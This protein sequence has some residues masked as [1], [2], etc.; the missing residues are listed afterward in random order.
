MSDKTHMHGDGE[1]YSGI[2]PAKQPNKSGEPPAEAVEGRPLTKENM[3]Q[4]NRYRTQ[5]LVKQ[6]GPCARS[7]K[8][9]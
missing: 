1:S 5:K 6:V 3:D 2:V 8:E 9:G 4:P 7:S